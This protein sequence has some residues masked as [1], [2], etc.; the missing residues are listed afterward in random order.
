MREEENVSIWLMI[1]TWKE[2]KDL[3]VWKCV[4]VYVCVFVDVPAG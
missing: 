2:K 1:K 3:S 4:Y